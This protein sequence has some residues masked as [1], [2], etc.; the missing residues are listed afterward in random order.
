MAELHVFCA[1][2][3]GRLAR[4]TVDAFTAKHA[5][6]EVNLEVGGST[7]GVNR[8]LAGEVFDVLILADDSDISARLMPRYA[9][10][11]FI[12]GGN[13]MTVIGCDITPENWAERLCDPASVITHR[14]PYDDPGGYRA[15]MALMLA[16]RV[17]PGLSA[18]ILGNPG[19]KGLDRAQYALSK[20]GSKPKF[21]GPQPPTPGHYDISYRSMPVGLGFPYVDLPAVMNLGDPAFEDVYRTVSFMVDGAAGEASE[22]VRGTTIFHAVCLPKNA[23]QPEA[24][25]T[26][27]E[28]FLKTDFVSWGFTPVQRVVGNWPASLLPPS[29]S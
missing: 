13:A 2:V 6:V 18:R 16:D 15:V 28:E 8:A 11:Y 14:N 12:W 22:E 17:E 24:A 23:A 29:H 27:V 9:N 25:Q 5:D 20:D 7:A 10:G 21:K 1:G 26:F 3:A 19:Y 4:K